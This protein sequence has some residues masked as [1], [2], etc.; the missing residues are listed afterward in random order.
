[1]EN[2]GLVAKVDPYY[3]EHITQL[4]LTYP[5]W[6][7]EV[8]SEESQKKLKDHIDYL[9]GT[10]FPSA[11][12]VD[13]L[14]NI[15]YFSKG[16]PI[17]LRRIWEIIKDPGTDSVVAFVANKSLKSNIKQGFVTQE[18]LGDTN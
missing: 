15:Y 1:M 10:K 12:D 7:P 14:W 8:P 13:S 16:D 4:Y 2:C 6:A 17:Y 3:E 9:L 11:G 18:S 5:V